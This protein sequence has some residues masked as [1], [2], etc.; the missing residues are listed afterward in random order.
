MCSNN[1]L[2]KIFI[3][4]VLNSKK[5]PTTL[6]LP[7]KIFAEMFLPKKILESKFSNP[8]K[9]LTHPVTLNPQYPLGHLFRYIVFDTCF[10]R[11]RML[12]QK[13]NIK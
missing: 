2:P 6:K 7:Q 8:K 1:S 3:I 11:D 9:S 10:L 13:H 4:T 12:G 5:I